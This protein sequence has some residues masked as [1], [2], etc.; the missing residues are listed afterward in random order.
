MGGPGSG[1]W[2]RWDTKP[3][4]EHYRSIDV[5]EWQRQGLLCAG[6]RF[7][8][9]WW[10]P[11][12]QQ[13]G[14]VSVAIVEDAVELSYHYN[15][16]PVQDRILLTWTRCRYGGRR[17]WFLCPNGLRQR[18][19]AKLYLAGHDFRCRPCYRLT[20]GSQREDRCYRAMRKAH[21]I[22]ERLGGRPGFVYPFPPKPKGMH[23]RT[24]RRWEAKAKEAEWQCWGAAAERFGLL[25]GM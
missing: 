4:V 1:Q 9:A 7:I 8:W 19:V 12:G 5:R 18:R 20:Y 16:E 21:K 11:H 25:D 24:Y 14:S 10:D 22:Q 13:T 15:G 23:W 3:T 6:R 17:P 2:Y